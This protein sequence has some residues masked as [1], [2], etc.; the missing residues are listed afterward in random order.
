MV[1]NQIIGLTLPCFTCLKPG[2]RLSVVFIVIFFVSLGWRFYKILKIQVIC[3]VVVEFLNHSTSQFNFQFPIYI[4]LHG[5][6]I[7]FCFLFFY[8]VCFFLTKLQ[9]IFKNN[10]FDFC[11]SHLSDSAKKEQ[12]IVLS[13]LYDFTVV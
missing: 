3:V 11:I 9:G 8:A 13:H 2:Y 6:E 10:L 5:C 7:Y 1:G 4:T 12:P